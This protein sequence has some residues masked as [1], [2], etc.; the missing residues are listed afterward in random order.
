[1]VEIPKF[2]VILFCFICLFLFL[3]VF[4]DSEITFWQFKYPGFQ[5]SA[6]QNGSSW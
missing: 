2:L 6:E 1:M 4:G 5:F 3:Q